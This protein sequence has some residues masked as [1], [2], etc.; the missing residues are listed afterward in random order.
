M[1]WKLREKV[2]KLLDEE[3]GTSHKA[4]GGKVSVALVYPNTYYVGM[5]NLGFQAIY[6][7]LNLHPHILC[8]RGF[9]PDPEDLSEY[10][11]TRTPLCSWESGR[12]LSSFDMVAFSVSYENDFL[13]ILKILDLA[14]IPLLSE[15]RGPGY[16]LVV[17]GGICAFSN[18]EPMADFFDLFFLGEGE[19]AFPEVVGLFR[20]LGGEG[21]GREAFLREAATAGGVYIPRFYRVSY[22]REGIIEG[23]EAIAPAPPRVKRHYVAQLDRCPVLS[24]LRTPHT[25]FGDML[26]LEINRGCKGGCRF[27]LAGGIYRP[28][29][30]RTREALLQSLEGITLPER[31]GLVGACITDHPQIEG[32]CQD[33]LERGFAVSAP[34][35]RAGAIPEGLLRYLAQSGQKTITLA[36]EAASERLRHVLGK[37]IGEEDFLHTVEQILAQKIPNIKLYFMV[38]LPSE[39]EEEVLAIA[40]MAKKV[41][42]LMLSAAKSSARLGQVTL[43]LN[44][45]VPK[46]WTP[47]Q[48]LGFEEVGRLQQ[49]VG[50]IK[51]ALKGTSN[52]IC[53]HDLPQWGYI[54]A[55]LARGDRQLGG[56]LLLAHRFGGRWKKAFQEWSLNPDFYVYRRRQPEEVFPWDHLEDGVSKGHLLEEFRRAGL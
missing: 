42:H 47:F 6:H 14:R 7:Y 2:K 22:G 52:I 43:S 31:V 23:V 25:E 48:W 11:R 39:Q 18:P 54:Q 8:E 10:E 37:G 38:G 19:E 12:P 40:A 16:P 33:L 30:F 9:L 13:N 21:R 15:Q 24:F 44:A 20:A 26:L 27:C 35:L 3:R 17:M 55:L 41:K 34:S 56:L 5:S 32:L 29:R 28:F 50:A 4:F 46:P 53:F 36:P 51:R 1:S 45:F 49:K